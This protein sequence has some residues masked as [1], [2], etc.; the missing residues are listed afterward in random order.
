MAIKG[1]DSYQATMLTWSDNQ[2]F[3]DSSTTHIQ[4][5]HIKTQ[6][7]A[8]VAIQEWVQRV[9]WIVNMERL[10][11][12]TWYSSISRVECAFMWQMIYCVSTTRVYRH[13]L[14]PS[15]DSLTWCTH[16]AVGTPEYIDH[17]MVSCPTLATIGN[18]FMHCSHPWPHLPQSLGLRCLTLLWG[19]SYHNRS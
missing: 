17:C 11:Q 15:M 3:F 7:K 8:R 1:E 16:Y 14:L 12:E 10:W 9:G 2:P 4:K 5:L 6:A 19:M 18:G 13:F